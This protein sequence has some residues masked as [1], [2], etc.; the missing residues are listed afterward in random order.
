MSSVAGKWRTENDCVLS[1]HGTENGATD[2]VDA[3]SEDD[4]GTLEETG[5]FEE[6]RD[7]SS[8]PESDSHE[9]DVESEDQDD[10]SS[11][12]YD[13]QSVASDEELPPLC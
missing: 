11:V 13:D 12:L 7:L 5:R 3:H 8:N 2:M 9:S 1:T 4:C 6:E 10:V